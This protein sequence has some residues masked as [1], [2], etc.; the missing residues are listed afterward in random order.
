MASAKRQKSDS[1]GSK[2]KISP[3][4][5]GFPGRLTYAIKTRRDQVPGLSLNKVAAAANVDPGNLS[6]LA[7][8]KK[9]HPSADTAWLLSHALDVRLVWLITGEEPSGLDRPMSPDRAAALSDTP[10]GEAEKY[11]A[12][13]GSARPAAGDHVYQ[14]VEGGGELQVAERDQA[15]G[16]LDK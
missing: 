13:R 11:R 2:R 3:E 10:E 14:Q 8:G 7:S 16:N 4:M 5:R 9:A 12:L 1:G 6:K 15:Y